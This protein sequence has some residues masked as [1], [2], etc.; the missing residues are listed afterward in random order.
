MA[1]NFGLPLFEFERL[2]GSAAVTCHTPACQAKEKPNRHLFLTLSTKQR[3]HMILIYDSPLIL[4]N[5]PTLFSSQI[6]LPLKGIEWVAR[7]SKPF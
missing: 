3:Y 6:T 1:T 5:T 4:K 7:G 2:D